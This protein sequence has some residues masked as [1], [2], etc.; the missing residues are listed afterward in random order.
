[1]VSAACIMERPR[2]SES[3]IDSTAANSLAV[4][5]LCASPYPA[6]RRIQCYLHDG[7]ARLEGRLPTYHQKQMA[8]EIIRHAAGVEGIDNRIVVENDFWSSTN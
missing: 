8:Q 2:C 5:A 6:I 7:I 4:I 3:F 1:M